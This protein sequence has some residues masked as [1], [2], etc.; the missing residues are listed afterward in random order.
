MTLQLIKVLRPTKRENKI[1][2]FDKLTKYYVVGYYGKNY[3]KFYLT[4]KTGT[5]RIT[6]LSF[7]YLRL[8]KV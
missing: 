3:T 7:D 2:Y 1:L 4:N 6:K 5:L 8:I